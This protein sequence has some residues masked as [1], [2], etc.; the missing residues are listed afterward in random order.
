MTTSQ[1]IPTVKEK[2]PNPPSP[3]HE[4]AYGGR[5]RTSD[6]RGSPRSVRITRLDRA[7]RRQGDGE[8]DG[9]EHRGV[10]R[11]GDERRDRNRPRRAVCLAARSYPRLPRRVRVVVCRSLRNGGRAT[12]QRERRP[13]CLASDSVRR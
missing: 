4:Y 3:R 10:R 1:S 8:G 5:L 2:S 11:A 9:P 7:G 13:R 12:G 6:G